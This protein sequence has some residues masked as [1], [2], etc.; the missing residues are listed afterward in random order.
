MNAAQAKLLREHEDHFEMSNRE[1]PFRVPKAGLSESLQ[2]TIRSMSTGLDAPPAPDAGQVKFGTAMR[3]APELSIPAP[4][5]APLGTTPEERPV[6]GNPY[7]ATAGTTGNEPVVQRRPD[8]LMDTIMGSV[9]QER[10]AK[11]AAAD[12]GIRPKGTPSAG[13]E[14]DTIGP[15]QTSAPAAPRVGGASMPGMSDIR[16]GIEVQKGAGVM[17]ANVEA[18]RARQ[19]AQALGAYETQLQANALDDKQRAEAAQARSAEMMSAYKTASDELRN[20]NTTVDPGRGYASKSTPGKIVGWIGLALSS[21]TPEGV[22]RA[23]AAIERAIDRDLDAQKAEHTLRLQK[24]RQ[25]LDAAQ[26]AYA[27]NHQIFQDELAT[28]NATKASLLGLA[29][30][31]LRKISAGAAGPAAQAQAAALAGALQAK[32][33]ELVN[34]AANTAF[35]NNTQ[36][37]LANAQ[38]NK[39][40]AGGVAQANTLTEVRERAA[41]L[42]SNVAAAKAL[43]AKSG[44]FELAGGEQ[45]ELN[46]LLTDIAIDS[47]KLKDP[48]SVARESEVAN[49]QRSL[50]VE[51]G[52]LLTSNGTANKLLDSFAAG[53]DRREDEALR[54]RGLP[55]PVR[56][57]VPVKK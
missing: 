55:V 13:P 2:A 34:A 44:T 40:A 43:I 17:G 15:V 12:L 35:D 20:I 18:E 1:G 23:T 16:G 37:I 32:Q 4:A 3:V 53:V 45:Q 39:P 7:E 11:G 29:E 31:T 46:R 25:R 30:N 38:A 56:A 51:A 8:P 54:V 33:G 36:R 19:S 42:R 49:E 21:L 24:G 14:V 57:K 52:S 48:T 22:T 10:A 5:Q 50:G 47:A 6:P 9:D 28:S 41:N 27:M 26:S